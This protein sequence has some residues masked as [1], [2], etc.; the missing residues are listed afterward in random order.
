MITEDVRVA[1]VALLRADENDALVLCAWL[2]D[3]C[4]EYG[5]Y[6]ICIL[7]SFGINNSLSQEAYIYDLASKKFVL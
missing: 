1:D 2:E 7:Y 5:I 3:P 6:A 4:C